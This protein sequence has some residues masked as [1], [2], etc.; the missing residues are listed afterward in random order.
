[1]RDT[2]LF[3]KFSESKPEHQHWCIYSSKPSGAHLLP[4]QCPSWIG[5][6]PRITPCIRWLYL[7]GFLHPVPPLS[8]TLTFLKGPSLSL[9]QCLPVYVCLTFPRGL[10]WVMQFWQECPRSDAVSSP[11]I[12]SGGLVGGGCQRWDV[13]HWVKMMFVR[14]LHCIF[15]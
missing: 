6:Q 11:S 10:I 14:F 8:L 7:L 3:A 5:I 4:Q 9:V 15:N 13:N 1:M 2:L 12:T